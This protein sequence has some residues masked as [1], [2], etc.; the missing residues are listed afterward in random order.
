MA[1]TTREL[2]FSDL[3][4]NNLRE[5]FENDR[6]YFNQLFENNGFKDYIEENNLCSFTDGSSNINCEYYST[7]SFKQKIIRNDKMLKMI[8]INIRRIAANM[9]ELLVFLSNL[10][11]DFNLII[12]S[13][14][15]DDA[16]NY[17]NSHNFP[18]YDFFFKPPT[19]NRYGGAAI[20][21]REGTGT[22]TIRS[23]LQMEKNVI[24][25]IVYG[26]IFG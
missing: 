2:P 15:G 23:D 19:G 7:D 8:N 6:A 17:L 16:E 10:E 13:E 1:N 26:K 14:I 24:A 21:V 9:A 3:T 12:L 20:M 25:V 11:T 18:G 5:L 4:D 22:V